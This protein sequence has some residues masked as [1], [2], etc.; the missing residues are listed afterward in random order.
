MSEHSL[1]RQRANFIAYA[2]AGLIVVVCLFSHLGAIGLVGPDEPRYAWIARAMATSGDWVTPRLY[3][4]P[5]FEKP[6]LYYWAAS[7]GI[8]GSLAGRMGGA[9]AVRFCGAGGSYC[10]RLARLEILRSGILAVR[11]AF[12]ACS[13]Y[14]LDERCRDWVRARGGSR[15]V[16]QRRSHRR[17]GKRRD[18][19]M[20]SRGFAF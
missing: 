12:L 8:L 15:Y 10:D 4:Q 18:C 2:S 20:S 11:V 14:F 3:G 19:A 7:A 6:V 9:T 1:S 5:W 16:V 17:D 13:S